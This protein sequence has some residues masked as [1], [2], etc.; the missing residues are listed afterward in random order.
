MP[1]PRRLLLSLGG[2]AVVAGGGYGIWRARQPTNL[3]AS[4]LT[5]PIKA[6]TPSAP[7]PAHPT[8]PGMGVR[9]LGD[10]KAPV[11]VDEWFSLT[12]PHCARFAIDV[13]PAIR[14]TL[15]DSGRLYYVFRDF[16]LDQVALMAAVVARHLPKPQYAG[17]VEALLASQDRWAFARAANPTVEIGKVAALAGMSTDA[18]DAALKDTALRDAILTDQ[19][20]AEKLHGVNSTPTFILNGPKA[21]GETLIGEQSLA[22]FTKTVAA[23]GG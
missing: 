2:A 18:Y 17:F 5:A 11:R 22:G 9:A 23:A 3:L 13:L 16:P 20:R 21:K 6:A 12:C 19:V 14:K 1:V 10:P 4:A 15:I 7:V 8:I